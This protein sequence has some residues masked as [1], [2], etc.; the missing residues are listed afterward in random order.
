MADTARTKAALAAILADN[1]SGA[2]S[3]QDVRDF[4]ETMHP[5]FGSL[6]FSSA[7]ATTITVA[8]TFYKA[9]GTT[10]QVSANRFTV[11][12]NR[13]TY[14]GT[15][16]IHTHIAASYSMTTAG[17]NDIL[18]I[19]IA[20]GGSVLTHSIL[21]RKIGTGSDVGA[22]ACHADVSLATNEYIELWVTNYDATATV[23]L[24]LGYLFILGM[25][26]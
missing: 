25:M 17:T 9:A 13:L 6:Y 15:P 5:S 2:I 21:K 26:V 7:A 12:T 19:A 3:P 23:T 24:D 10:T 14:T 1:T 11:G 18:G 20:K 22:A 8:G 4:L 16:T